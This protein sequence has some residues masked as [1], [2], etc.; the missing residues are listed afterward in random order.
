MACINPRLSAFAQKRLLS[1]A[2]ALADATADMVEAAKHC[3]T[4]PTNENSQVNI[5]NLCVFLSLSLSLFHYVNLSSLSPS[6][7]HTLTLS[8]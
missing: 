3:A 2:K 5:E 1:A 8:T 7:S 6:L 4:S